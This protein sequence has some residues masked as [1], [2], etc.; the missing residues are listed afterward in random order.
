MTDLTPISGWPLVVIVSLICLKIVRWIFGRWQNQ[1]FQTNAIGKILELS[2]IAGTAYQ[3]SS[4]PLVASL[5]SAMKRLIDS[6][7]N[8][9]GGATNAI[10]VATI[11]ALAL[12][13]IFG[14]Q[15]W[16]SDNEWWTLLFALAIL[17]L[18]AALPDLARYLGFAWFL[19]L[20]F[21][22]I[23]FT[24]FMWLGNPFGAA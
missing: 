21:W 1:R 11:L 18:S 20:W 7:A 16:K 5:V 6:M 13:A 4:V 15:Y 8:T 14:S 3:L 24:F 17:V 2:I 23:I 9:L 22:N 12:A 19:V 10:T